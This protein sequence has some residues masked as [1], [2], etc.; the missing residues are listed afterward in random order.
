MLANI[1]DGFT[2][3]A[4]LIEKCCI[5]IAFLASAEDDRICWK[6]ADSS[7][8]E[9]LVMAMERF[10]FHAT[11][12]T[13]ASK[14][15]A[16]LS[17]EQDVRFLF[18]ALGGIGRLVIGVNFFC[19]NTVFLEHAYS[20]ISNL[21][22]DVGED[23]LDIRILIRTTVETIAMHPDSINLTKS[24]L[25]T[26]L[27]ISMK[28]LEAK[29]IIANEGGIRTTIQTMERA[30]TTPSLIERGFSIIWSLAVSNP[31]QGRISA[32][33]GIF[34]VV[35]ALLATTAQCGSTVEEQEQ[36]ERVQLEGC[37]CLFTLALDPE[38]RF[39][40]RESGGPEAIALS[41]AVHKKSEKFQAEVCKLMACLSTSC[42]V[43]I[44][45][46]QEEALTTITAMRNFPRTEDVQVHG[47]MAIVN[48]LH[49]SNGA[50][51][52]VTTPAIVEAVNRAAECFP[53]Q[54]ASSFDEFNYII[55]SL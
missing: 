48:F 19:D 32:E 21:C 17:A 4:N 3:N 5:F 45:I 20:A 42:G 1:M 47:C 22:R 11:I 8:V 29:E 24:A 46:S 49:A 44:E 28:G 30:I 18:A 43:P 6:I 10:P 40:I 33:R 2:Q 27:N 51:I 7:G 34:V 31:N 52:A 36:L 53:F 13:E 37:G 15:I 26:L 23:F 41:A 25:S 9:K 39:A 50:V 14:A 35:S 55:H 38:N 54:C 16:H 12:Q